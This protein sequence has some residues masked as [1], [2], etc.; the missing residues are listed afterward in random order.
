MGGGGDHV[1]IT[2]PDINNT[3]NGSSNHPHLQEQ[4]AGAVFRFQ[5]PSHT[6][7]LC[8][9]NVMN[10]LKLQFQ[11]EAPLPPQL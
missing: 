5:F 3:P 1:T 9:R 11:V 6:L 10:G 7:Q 2:R 4:Q 8:C